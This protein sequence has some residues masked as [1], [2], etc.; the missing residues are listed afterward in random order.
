M[1]EV[2]K[3]EKREKRAA[4]N[5]TG[6]MGRMSCGPH[7]VHRRV[8]ARRS[9]LWSGL[10][11]QTHA[12]TLAKA[13][14]LFKQH[15]YSGC[16]FHF[17]GFG[18]GVGGGMF[19]IPKGSAGTQHADASTGKDTCRIK[20]TL[21][22]QGLKNVSPVPENWMSNLFFHSIAWKLN[23]SHDNWICR[24][25]LELLRH[26]SLF[27]QENIFVS[28]EQRIYHQLK[29]DGALIIT[30]SLHLLC[31]VTGRTLYSFYWPYANLA[32]VIAA[33]DDGKLA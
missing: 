33:N 26:R 29:L 22:A 32:I 1:R 11:N 25:E 15:Y 14:R 2:R 13:H 8:L 30:Q 31:W 9:E 20:Q 23:L 10:Y 6:S 7:P 17:K 4:Q 12:G 18:W 19:D 3:Y 5:S 16:Y 21:M 27:L 24:L 28:W